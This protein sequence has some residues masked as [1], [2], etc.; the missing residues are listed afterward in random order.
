M[1]RLNMTLQQNAP[2]AHETALFTDQFLKSALVL[3]WQQ[4]TMR[5]GEVLY[6][7]SQSLK[8]ETACVTCSLAGKLVHL[9]PVNS[10]SQL[11]AHQLATIVAPVF[12]RSEMNR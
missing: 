5:R 9:A 11:T 4:M 10:Q 1:S 3:L 6:Q 8:L 2:R 12:H 7:A